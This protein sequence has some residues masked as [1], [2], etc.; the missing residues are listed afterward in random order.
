MPRLAKYKNQPLRNFRRKRVGGAPAVSATIY[1]IGTV[2]K[3]FRVVPSGR[4]RRWVKLA[5]AKRKR[6]RKRLR[7]TVVAAAAARRRSRSPRRRS[8]RQGYNA[9]TPVWTSDWA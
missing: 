5:A 6:S 3:G 9:T 7:R 1:T 2:M 8:R 4:S